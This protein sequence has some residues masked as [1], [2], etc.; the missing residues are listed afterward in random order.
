MPDRARP[1]PAPDDR[2]IL[3]HLSDWFLAQI[4]SDN[5]AR[6]AEL[7][8]QVTPPAPPPA[9]PPLELRPS[10]V[11]QRP[12]P[13]VVTNP[14]AI[15]GL[16]Q[17]S[18]AAGLGAL[19]DRPGD[20]AAAGRAAWAEAKR[21]P[22]ASSTSELATPSGELQ[23]RGANIPPWLQLVI[24]A[25]LDPTNLV[26]GEPFTDLAKL[27][28]VA[29]MAGGL[30]GFFSRVDR[31]AEGVSKKGIHPNK[32]ASLL[33][34]GASQEEVAYRNL[35]DLIT[36]KGNEL[37]TKKELAQ[38]LAANPP[39]MPTL[40]RRGQAADE[41][42]AFVSQMEQRYGVGYDTEQLTPAERAVQQ[43]LW[44]RAS[45]RGGFGGPKYE[46]YTLPG[47]ERYRETLLTLPYAPERH[48][49]FTVTLTRPNG[50]HAGG[51]DNVSPEDV[52]GFRRQYEPGGWTVNAE[53]T[54][55]YEEPRADQYRSG[56]WDEPN[57]LTHI[58]TK[59]RTLPPA[60]MRPEA[61]VERIIQDVVG[62]RFPEHIAS[63]G[64]QLAV[65]QGLI[66]HDEA[67]RFGHARGF[68]NY[69]QAPEG[70]RG[71]FIEEIQSDWHQA[72]KRQGYATV[73]PEMQAAAEKLRP[74][75][76]AAE[77]SLTEKNVAAE[78]ARKTHHTLRQQHTR[79]YLPPEFA[80]LES[81]DQA[82]HA[83][84]VPSQ[85]GWEVDPIDAWRRARGVADSIPEVRAANTAV[86]QAETTLSQE[87]DR[88][89]H[90]R[91]QLG[92]LESPTG[93]P[94]A[95]F[96]ETWPDLALK[97][98]LLDVA[99][100]RDLSWLG[101][102]SGATQNE[103]YDLAKQVSRIE[104]DP[105]NRRLYAY[106]HAG[107]QVIDEHAE[108]DE[109]VEH[110]G[111]GPAAKLQEQITR[112]ADAAKWE[113]SQWTSDFDPNEQQY[114]VY[115]ANGEPLHTFGGN[116]ETFHTQREADERIDELLG[117]E[118]TNYGRNLPSL[119]GLDLQVGGEGMTSFYDQLL[120]ARLKKLLKPFGGAVERGAVPIT[121]DVVEDLP[122]FSV[123]DNFGHMRG[124]WPTRQEAEAYIR[125]PPPTM[126]SYVSAEG[127]ARV[128]PATGGREVQRLVD[129]P[130]WIAHL[131]PEMK[132]RIRTEGFPLMSLLPPALVAGAAASQDDDNTNGSALLAAAM[133]GVPL[134]P[135]HLPRSAGS[136]ADALK[137]GGP[138]MHPLRASA[139]E[140]VAR[141]T[142]FAETFPRLS[143]WRGINDPRFLAS[144]GGDVDEA[145]RHLRTFAATSPATA[146]PD[147]ARE[148]AALQ[149]WRV[150]HPEQDITHAQTRRLRGQPLGNASS[151]WQ[152]VND[153]W[154]DRVMG[155]SK[156]NDA[157]KVESFGNFMQDQLGPI[158]HPMRRRTRP[159]DINWAPDRT[160]LISLP[161][162][163]HMLYGVGGQPEE[164]L[165]AEWAP[166]RERLSGWEGLTHPET[167]APLAGNQGGFT[168]KDLYDRVTWSLADTLANQRPDLPLQQSFGR[169]W[170]GA[171]ANKLL[172][173]GKQVPFAGGLLDIYGNV[174]LMEPGALQDPDAIYRAL[175]RRKDWYNLGWGPGY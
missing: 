131:T 136:L 50:E 26:G 123:R 78:A 146:V 21:T 130:A 134:F 88:I 149:A 40:S 71:R 129:E 15:S 144:M 143:N 97:Q 43:G 2:S 13:P 81:F 100:R 93:V 126:A 118:Q 99:N 84:S 157:L 167:G 60:P 139:A 76:A 58:R 163:M 85:G 127:G 101:F 62:A 12:R 42:D 119:E 90:L 49:R 41:Y 113:R 8:R 59:E 63:G 116:V 122:G 108:P 70:P 52:A 7:E 11:S 161:H 155:R 115:D 162:D 103:R 23:K 38:H 36:R 128:M 28:A 30:P 27:G 165:D 25:E 170:T 138:G 95:P 74:E 153:A 96:K 173:Q 150:L 9:P 174:G 75:L 159:A 73:T 10:R 19:A 156:F 65:R 121:K 137:R 54:G 120:P 94:D 83:F 17:A 154:N 3:Q 124:W 82:L 160:P 142:D 37:I 133:A 92:A 86:Q 67:A 6:L 69:P 111:Q 44:N 158:G 148:A 98:Q 152:N 112:H 39:P 5:R 64:P 109:L 16:P 169:F 51:W 135:V 66:T 31:I 87:L 24:D 175:E 89:N 107:Q 46:S 34:S 104:Y 140:R 48:P 102:T 132:E 91:T 68:T 45:Q 147:N 168:N 114:V 32:L 57:I 53:Q 56:H 4:P 151:K 14:L 1:A 61:E 172:T 105:R 29:H 166:L 22:F 145:R 79:Q 77:A 125:T 55:F 110:I 141:L 35:P 47:G 20:L 117:A 72:G 33:K 106:D 164:L 18:F 80:H 171:Q